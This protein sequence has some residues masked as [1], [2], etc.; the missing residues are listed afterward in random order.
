MAQYIIFLAIAPF[1]FGGILLALLLPRLVHSYHRFSW[2]KIFNLIQ[3]GLSVNFVELLV[4][5]VE[6]KRVLASI[7]YIFVG[8]WASAWFFFSLEYTGQLRGKRPWQALLF[9]LPFV[10]CACGIVDPSLVWRALRFER[11]EWILVMRTS[12]Y[13]PLALSLFVQC[14]SLMLAGAVILLRHTALSHSLFRRQTALMI[15]G[16]VVPTCFNLVFIL[17][18]FPDWNKDFSAPMAALG[19]LCFSVGCLR[20]RLFSVVPVSRQKLFEHMQVGYIVTDSNDAIVDLNVAACRI[21]GK[22]EI[23]L[24]GRQAAPELESVE[25]RAMIVRHPLASVPG[26]N[27]EG[28]HIELREGEALA[29]VAED[30]GARFSREE[31]QFLSLGELRVVEMLAQ[32]L[33][34]KEI[35]DR[36]GLSVNTVKFHLSNAYAKTGTHSRAELVHRVA[37]IT[38]AKADEVP[39]KA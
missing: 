15:V 35:A 32:N 7:D 12:G 18:V 24:L 2:L 19:G 38:N 25:G 29:A 33:S 30:D 22:S 28:W 21:L 26:A 8:S 1:A 31:S 27:L 16:V 17:K 4:T 34:N 3:L 13:G 11:L 36:L 6:L 10:C 5:D 39:V 23:F 9:V 37:E 20:Y 14:Y